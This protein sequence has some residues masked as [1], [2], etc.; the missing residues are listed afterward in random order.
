M[1]Y[2]SKLSQH[3][4]TFIERYG[5]R[6]NLYK[7][8]FGGMV[9]TVTKYIELQLRMTGLDISKKDQPRNV[10]AIL[11]EFDYC[12]YLK[13]SGN[14]ILYRGD[15]YSQI[16]LVYEYVN[17]VVGGLGDVIKDMVD[18]QI[19]LPES[20]VKR[21]KDTYL[22]SYLEVN[23]CEVMDKYSRKYGVDPAVIE[24][25]KVISME[26]FINLLKTKGAEDGEKV[27]ITAI[28]LNSLYNKLT[29]SGK[30]SVKAFDN[31]VEKLYRDTYYTKTEGGERISTKTEKARM[32]S[33]VY[34]VRK[35]L[36]EP[37]KE[38]SILLVAWL[39]TGKKKYY[40]MTKLNAHEAVE[41]DI[42][43]NLDKIASA[44]EYMNTPEYLSIDCVELLKHP[45]TEYPDKA[46][47]EVQDTTLIEMLKLIKKEVD[48]EDTNYFLLM[49]RD[50]ACKAIKNKNYGL[51]EKQINV[52]NKVYD[53][54]QN[55]DSKKTNYS[56]VNKY[57][58]DIEGKMKA[59]YKTLSTSDFDNML[60]SIINRGKKNKFL[61][62]KQY[63]LLMDNYDSRCA[64]SQVY[65]KPKEPFDGTKILLD[66]AEKYKKEHSKDNT[67]SIIEE[68]DYSL[69]IPEI[70]L[71]DIF[72]RD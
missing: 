32:F 69:D 63:N 16:D 50:I 7:F 57:T 39:F 40:S 8:A 59:L 54:I 65:P 52:V 33:S 47:D 34:K 21:Y 18:N 14:S 41:L 31:V 71:N 29:D 27:F 46:D 17:S 13:L 4:S 58:P 2:S 22:P 24:D 30:I 62:E 72:R 42:L 51:S 35:A 15:N 38:I 44:I 28:K 9:S 61:S 67:D 48:P 37:R 12:A 10:E 68:V 36:L 56:G 6:E 19:P 49:A 20:F 26:Y 1:G 55:K 5:T 45:E 25:S 64:G 43:V 53:I 60:R 70:D 3:Y 66:N 23:Y 11:S